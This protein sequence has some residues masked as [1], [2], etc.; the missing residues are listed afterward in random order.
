[1]KKTV[2]KRRK[3]VPAA[4][5][6][7]S[8]HAQM[9]SSQ[10]QAGRGH[11]HG[12]LSDQAAAEALVQV[13]RSAQ[14]QDRSA[15]ED[16]D[17]DIDVRSR[18]RARRTLPGPS[19]SGGGSGVDRPGEGGDMDLD[20][21]RRGGDGRFDRGEGQ[22]VQGLWVERGVQDTTSVFGAFS[23]DQR[24]MN[25]D[26][27]SEPRYGAQ[28][29]YGAPMQPG[30]SSY[31][32]P[33]LSSAISG[34]K[35]GPRYVPSSSGRDSSQFVGPGTA[36]S[37]FPRPDPSGSRTVSPVPHHHQTNPNFAAGPSATYH[38]PP[39]H[40]S[41]FPSGAGISTSNPMRQTSPRA[42][43][44]ARTH[45]SSMSGRDSVTGGQPPV[46]TLHELEKHLH[47]L[48]EQKRQFQEMITRTELMMAGI[49]RGIEEMRAT[50]ASTAATGAGA[51]QSSVAGPSRTTGN[52]GSS[53]PLA[54]RGDRARGEGQV[55]S[56]IQGDGSNRD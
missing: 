48:S 54:S 31:D 46:P 22:S 30:S 49:Q 18:K 12:R 17:D 55:W 53:V 45:I 1:M 5:P 56:V 19:G 39:P 43:S 16:S 27:G 38:L 42:P 3:R 44:P 40:G 20:T 15:G 35:G 8:V 11:I 51:G 7:S 14:G 23:P 41:Y 10:G 37:A 33:P 50:S 21:D 28:R 29:T 47:E 34:D 6:G 25:Y 24:S 36:P 2:I 26:S 32:L 4:G 9:S 13:G 52:G